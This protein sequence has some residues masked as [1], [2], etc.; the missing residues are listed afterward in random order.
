MYVLQVYYDIISKNFIL[1]VRSILKITFIISS[2]FTFTE[3]FA[4][5]LNKDLIFASSS[6][7]LNLKNNLQSDKFS[8]K[9]FEIDFSDLY[10]LLIK[11]NK[12]LKILKSQITQN[13]FNLKAEKSSWY[14][15]I[16][17]TSSNFPK[18]STGY[19]YEK[20]AS[21]QDTFTDELEFGGSLNFEWDLIK[22]SR[23]LD[24]EIASE[25]VNNA[26]L[27]FEN[28]LKE[29]FLEAS[30]IFF[31]IQ[32]SSQNIQ[33]SKK[34]LE[35]SSLALEE[36]QN[37]YDS[38]I[39]NKLDV[40]EA[41]TQFGRD[42]IALIKRLGERKINENKLSKI[43]NL[44]PNQKPVIEEE[45]EILSIWNSTYEQ[46]LNSAMAIREDIKIQKNN[47]KLNEKQALSILSGKKPTLTIYNNFSIS[48]S[49]GQS[50]VA[51]PSYE[52][53]SKNEGNTIGIKFSWNLFDGGLIKN[54]YKSLKDKSIE[55]EES[56]L[57]QV[58]KLKKD[59]QD[60]FINLGVYK[61][62]IIESYYQLESAKESL[63]LALK[64]LEAGLTT[65][66]EVVNNQGDLTEAESNFVNAITDYNKIIL[67]LER[68]S[69]LD[70]LSICSIKKENMDY[71]VKFILENELGTICSK[72]LVNL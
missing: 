14:P 40:L 5:N 38:G 65:Q 42:K 54:N 41:K 51:N 11:Q 50:N 29:L 62:N 16:G 24:I 53:V 46:S 69:G 55:L 48:S 26:K 72:D 66:R 17:F 13:I 64:R 52:N 31:L 28:K 39:G 32:E 61:E 49:S 71:F 18:Y 60:S 10:P 2:V 1:I 70:P 4:G 7:E 34:S 45:S 44:Q 47:I 59:L 30:E 25:K 27:N 9:D 19:N 33:I 67:K 57:L 35:I 8:E 56:Y 58:T 3:I 12:E 22:P 43:L 6:K 36:A 15:N 63:F 21:T 68:L 23:K 20:L 37:R